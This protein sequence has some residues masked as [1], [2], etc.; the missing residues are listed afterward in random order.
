[1]ARRRRRRGRRRSSAQ[2]LGEYAA[3]STSLIT[4]FWFP[5]RLFRVGSASAGAF[6]GSR[7]QRV[8]RTQRRV[9]RVDRAVYKK[10]TGRDMYPSPGTQVAGT[11]LRRPR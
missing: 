3:I 11:R 5:L 2:R 4:L 9:E 10:W 8:G 1:M 7:L 6:R